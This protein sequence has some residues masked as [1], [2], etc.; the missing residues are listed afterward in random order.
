MVQIAQVH[1]LGANSLSHESDVANGPAPLGG[2]FASVAKIISRELGGAGFPQ[3]SRGSDLFL[4][5]DFSGTH[6]GPLYTTYAF[7]LLDLDRNSWWLN[8]QRAFRSEALR[9]GRRLSF[10]ALN[11]GAR[12]RALLPFLLMAD[13]IEGA[14]I[15]IAVDKAHDT[16]FRPREKDA[17]LSL[18]EAWKPTVH[19]HLM[20]VTHLSALCT[21]LVSRPGQNLLWI[22]DQDDVTSNDAQI[23]AL[24]KLFG[25]VWSQMTDHNLG[26]LRLGS[27]KSDDGS[28]TL[29]D[30]A[31]IPDLA[32]GTA[33]ELLSQMTHQG[34]FPVV[35]L[36]NRMPQGLSGK[37]QRLIRWLAVSDRPLKRVVVTIRAAGP[38]RSTVSHVRLA[39]MPDFIMRP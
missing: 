20:R 31:A 3:D 16:L 7:L 18:I 1:A 21:T 29:E 22:C 17:D 4:V 32:A 13:E 38:G 12:R 11:D 27:T 34:L 23:V 36:Y 25:H 19:E 14:L 5:A 8:A 24:T 28:L 39:P 6:R 35:G 9:G 26:H 15:V 2:V 30:L 10:K 33:C 37:T